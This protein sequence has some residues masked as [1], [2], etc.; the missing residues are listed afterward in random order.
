M[1]TFYLTYQTFLQKGYETKVSTSPIF[2]LCTRIYKQQTLNIDAMCKLSD[3]RK[4][5]K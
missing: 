4:K 3:I 1:S 5:K 2:S